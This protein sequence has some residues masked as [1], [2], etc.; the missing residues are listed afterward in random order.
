MPPTPCALY[1]ASDAPHLQ[2]VYTGFAELARR[3]RITLTQRL[4]PA[5][6]PRPEAPPELRDHGMSLL[7]ATIDGVPVAF[8]V[9]DSGHVDSAVLARVRHYF[10]RSWEAPLLAMVDGAD[11]V[12]PLG[13]NVWVHDEPV[14]FLALRRIGLHRGVDRFKSLVRA[15]GAD[16][17]AGDALYTPRQRDLEAEPPIAQ[18]PRVL[19]LAEAWD[20]HQAHTAA[21]AAER[22]QMNATRAACMRALRHAFGDRV[23]CGF[24]PSAFAQREFADLAVPQPRATCK[25]G[26]LDQVRAHAICVA[27]TGLQHSVGWK[28]AEYVSMSRAIV[29]QQLHM[30][31]PGHFD[32]GVHYLP[33]ETPQQCV[34]QVARLLDDA[35]LRA[36]MMQANARYHGEH[37]KP[38]ALVAAAIEVV[39]RARTPAL[40]AA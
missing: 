26:Y 9:H 22:R 3:G 19:F 8:D 14:D 11:R 20:P 18:A 21:G 23:T 38:A 1:C 10:K 40:A 33:F 24:R 28:L 37:L 35:A 6:E 15:L 31:L 25:R 34:E 7:E 12:H 30:R 17:L 32:A 4:R 29:S 2:Q 39:R 16:R 36:A 13:L 5:A 27:T